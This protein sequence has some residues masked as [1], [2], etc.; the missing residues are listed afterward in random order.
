[1]WLLMESL[2]G[3]LWSGWKGK[4]L[5]VFVDGNGELCFRNCS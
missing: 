2:R 1:M 3:P 5:V 4:N